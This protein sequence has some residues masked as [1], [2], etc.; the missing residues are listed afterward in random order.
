MLHIAASKNHVIGFGGSDETGY[1][2][3]YRATP[4]SLVELFESSLPDVVLED[5]FLVR[6]MAEFH[7]LYGPI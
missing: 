7:G 1:D 6:K 2:V 3:A 4:L 5:A